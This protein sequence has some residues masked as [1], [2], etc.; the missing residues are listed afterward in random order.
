MLTCEYLLLLQI[1]MDFAPTSTQLYQMDSSLTASSFA[2]LTPTSDTASFTIDSSIITQQPQLISS[3]ASMA[4]HIQIKTELPDTPPRTPPLGPQHAVTTTVS[5]ISNVT[6][7][8]TSS[9]QAPTVLQGF[10]GFKIVLPAGGS[11]PTAG[12]NTVTHV[13]S[14]T[15][16]ALHPGVQKV[17]V[18][19]V[20][21]VAPIQPKASSA[22][23]CEC[24]ELN[25]LAFDMCGE[26]SLSLS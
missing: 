17:K 18:Q 16:V 10:N 15:A 6:T 1:Q 11:L 13:K 25:A 2:S 20:K 3:K 24:F 4:P 9:S 19:S 22:S 21:P 5:C 7:S 8:S 23:T 26:A 12:T 14:E